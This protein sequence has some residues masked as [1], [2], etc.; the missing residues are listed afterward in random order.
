MDSSDELYPAGIR[1]HGYYPGGG[2]G[3]VIWVDD[4]LNVYNLVKGDRIIV[5]EML[6]TGGFGLEF[7]DIF[8][9]ST[10]TG[11]YV[12]NTGQELWRGYIA[13]GGAA[14]YPHKVPRA[15]PRN[16]KVIINLVVNSSTFDGDFLI[17]AR[18]VKT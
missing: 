14:H 13:T 2:P 3:E 15:G 7:F 10:G 16:P 5:D 8:F 1:V 18:I 11:N 6:V 4:N 9:D 17:N 12:P